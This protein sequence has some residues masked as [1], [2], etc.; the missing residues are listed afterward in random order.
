[1]LID[2]L[3][4]QLKSTEPSIDAIKTFY[5][6]GKL[7]EKFKKLDEQLN[8]PDFWQH[9]DQIKISKE[10]QRLKHLGQQEFAAQTRGAY[11]I[12]L[13]IVPR[14]AGQLGNGPVALHYSD[15]GAAGL[16]GLGL[17]VIDQGRNHMFQLAGQHR[18]QLV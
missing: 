18:L 3:K 13:E 15:V 6:N 14:P 5:K 4:E 10:H 8:Q 9:P 17:E 7:E 11:V 2:D 16:E 12:F 1:M